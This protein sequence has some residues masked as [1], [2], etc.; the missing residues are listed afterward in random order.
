VLVL[1]LAGK[2]GLADSAT[3]TIRERIATL[4]AAGRLEVQGITIGTDDV[5]PEFYARRQFAPSWTDLRRIDTLLEAFAAAGDD[6]L[7]PEDYFL[8]RLRELRGAAGPGL[9]SADLDL[10]LTEALIRFAYHLRFGKVNP[11]T[12]DTN[13]NF[14]REFA[15]GVDPVAVFAE[16]VAADSPPAALAKAIPR[17]P[18]YRQLQQALAHYRALEARGGWPAI[19]EGRTLR[20]GERDARV[21]RLRERLGIS[22]DLGP[23]PQPVESDLYD[24]ALF[25]ALRRFQRRHALATDG[26]L[27]K[28][29]L[30]AL[31]VP[32]GRRIDQLRL[33]LERARWVSASVPADFVAV[34]IASFEAGFVKAGKL[35]WSSR[36]V[37]G[38]DARQTPIF[39]GDMTYL[40][41]NPT[42]T[43][44]PTILRKDILPKLKTDI[45][46]LRRENI[47]VLDRNG[48]VVDPAT[49]NWAAYTKSAP[50]TF[51][52]DPGPAN[53]LGR[54]KFMF[55]NEHAVYLHD[56][57][58]KQL[59]DKPERTF[60][61]GCIRVED[62]LRL[63]ELV[64]DDPGWTRAALEQA[65]ATGETRTVRLRR[66]IPVLLLYWTALADADGT[67]RFFR[68]VYG[69]DKELLAALDGAV[70]VDLPR[71]R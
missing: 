48:R 16:I 11:G 14:A 50:Y 22:G 44:P 10:L 15:A 28:R 40:V 23:D 65:I 32:V 60:S 49:V 63:A 6:G 26:V 21:P 34:N 52:Q 24:E 67:V 51:R 35:I 70:R 2:A 61:S 68:D 39:R 5:L 47:R 36:V 25:G 41:L 55:P 58:A 27:G 62:P 57:P 19:P 71:K 33:S 37:V 4:Q 9:P 69:R 3:D 42:W 30:A 53:S 54:I 56:T 1:A 8:G 29:T 13:W 17:G 59:F 31:N 66:P 20:P 43:V 45:D 46:Y 12:M 7:D 64:L 38:R 18:W